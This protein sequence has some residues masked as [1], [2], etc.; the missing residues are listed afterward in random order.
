MEYMEEE[1]GKNIDG[2]YE[3]CGQCLND[4]PE[5]EGFL[6]QIFGQFGQSGVET[7]GQFLHPYDPRAIFKGAGKLGKRA[8]QA[9]RELLFPSKNSPKNL[10]F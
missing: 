2:N 8:L 10:P 3:A 7:L 5:K 6:Q 9:G 4:A 1:N